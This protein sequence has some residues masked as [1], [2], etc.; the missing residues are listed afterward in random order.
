[1]YRQASSAEYTSAGTIMNRLKMA[2]P[3]TDTS[4]RTRLT[5]FFFSVNAFRWALAR[6]VMAIFVG[7]SSSRATSGSLRPTALPSTKRCS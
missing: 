1:M 5:G 2:S 3:T 7:S 6:S 4:R